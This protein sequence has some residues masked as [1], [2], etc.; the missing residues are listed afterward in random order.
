MGHRASA[1][2]HLVESCCVEGHGL[3]VGQRLSG[4]YRI[5]RQLAQGGMGAIY[6]AVHLRLGEKR[7]AIKVL[8]SRYAADPDAVARFRREALVTSRLRNEHIV[9]VHDF[10]VDGELA[11]LVM[12]L[13]DGEDLASRLDRAGSLSTDA[14]M[15]ILAQVV[16]A[17]DAAHRARIVHRDLKPQNIFLCTRG[18]RD[19]YVKVLDFGIS[20]LLDSSSALTGEHAL[21]GTPYYMAPEQAEGT[22]QD[23]DGRADV[24]AL[25]AILWELLTGRRAFGAATLS[26]V[27]YKVCQVDPPDVHLVRPDLPPAVSMVL[28]RALAKDRTGRTPDVVTLGRELAAALHGVAPDCVPPPAPGGMRTP[29][30]VTGPVS[31]DTVASLAAA[32]APRV[33]VPTSLA[34]VGARPASGSPNHDAGP[35]PA[36]ANPVSLA[37]VAGAA[38]AARMPSWPAGDEPAHPDPGVASRI[39]TGSVHVPARRS[40]RRA[41]LALVAVCVT[42]AGAVTGAVLGVRAHS[43]NDTGVAKVTAAAPPTQPPAPASQPPAPASQPSDEVAIFFAVEPAGA[44]VALRVDGALVTDRNLRRTRS[45]TPLLLTAEAPGYL[46]FRAEPVPDRDQV[47]TVSLRPVPAV[48]PKI[49]PPRRAPAPASATRTAT[50]RRPSSA[51]ASAGA[52]S[53]APAPDPAPRTRELPAPTASPVSR[54]LY[55]PS[56][57][58]TEQVPRDAGV[59]SSPAR[60]A[61]APPD[62][63][64]QRRPDVVA[65][66]GPQQPGAQPPAVPP[67]APAVPPPATT[68]PKPP[69]KTGTVFDNP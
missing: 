13:L 8:T 56:P 61:S 14:I 19:D 43:S 35:S 7:Y 48:A 31:R 26:A 38:L 22:P 15:R 1:G 28:R 47:V 6:E 27:L 64:A 39:A 9:E 12:E 21:L 59:S 11:Y 23:I 46:P 57:S 25:G 55:T 2:E 18:G 5:V 34:S 45:R 44:E 4:T 36:A 17:L 67:P 33:V 42:A 69:L 58:V 20:K 63:G 10:N 29:A 68:P 24:F 30:K 53:S 3:L 50:H 32:P 62:A 65:P 66:A 40:R 16:V 60:E 37:Q 54:P 41:I 51:S 49:A 52:G